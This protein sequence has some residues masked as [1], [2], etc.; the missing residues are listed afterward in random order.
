MTVN[1]ARINLI[2]TSFADG[3]SLTS[4]LCNY[5]TRQQ[6]KNQEI[7]QIIVNQ[8]I[9]EKKKWMVDLSETPEICGCKYK[10]GWEEASV[11]HRSSRRLPTDDSR[12]SP[13]VC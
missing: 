7:K 11:E 5:P 13:I 8:L 6:E 3:R 12:R 1:Y 4:I 9:D 10:S 2:G